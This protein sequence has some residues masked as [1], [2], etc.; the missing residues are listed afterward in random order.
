MMEV[1]SDLL[2]PWL[3]GAGQVYVVHIVRYNS[4]LLFQSKFWL[5]PHLPFP[6][7]L[8]EGRRDLYVELCAHI[9]LTEH[10]VIVNANGT[11]YT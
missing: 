3:V 11:F 9:A 1:Q 10:A 7:F 6:L 4:L 8:A 5:L 2:S